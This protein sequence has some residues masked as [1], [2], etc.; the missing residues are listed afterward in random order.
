[1]EIQERAMVWFRAVGQR[2]RCRWLMSRNDTNGM[3]PC[4]MC[5]VPENLENSPMP[6][7]F[8]PSTLPSAALPW[9]HSIA[10]IATRNAF[11]DDVLCY[12]DSKHRI[13]MPGAAVR[14]DDQSA[15][16]WLTL[17]L[18]NKVCALRDEGEG[19]KWG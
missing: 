3:T 5:H 9:H 12:E 17:N 6:A 1:M 2:R 4:A 14:L 18:S 10:H 19:I 11:T 8:G 7:T 16:V 13:V 15:P